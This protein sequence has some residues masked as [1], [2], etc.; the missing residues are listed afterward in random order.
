M[1]ARI[2]VLAAIVE[3]ENAQGKDA[4]DDGSRLRSA[5]ADNRI[6]RSSLEQAAAHIGGAEAVL[7]I[8]GGAQAVDLGA[9]EV[10]REHA[11]K[12]VLVVAAGRVARSG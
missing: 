5:D 1:A 7:Q 9:E 8:H 12:K 2:A 11:L 3:P 6:G 10:T 4:V